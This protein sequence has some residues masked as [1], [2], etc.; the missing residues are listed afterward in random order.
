MVRTQQP[1][2][3]DS[4]ELTPEMIERGIA[5]FREW[6]GRY[7]DPAIG[8]PPLDCEQREFLPELFRHLRMS[9]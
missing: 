3:H 5:K 6:E 8:Y 4:I 1:V 9:P 2:A 7:T